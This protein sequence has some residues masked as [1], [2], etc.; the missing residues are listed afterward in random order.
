MDEALATVLGL[1]FTFFVFA[2]FAVVFIKLAKAKK[3]QERMEE[4]KRKKA[5]EEASSESAE[6]RRLRREAELKRKTAKKYESYGYDERSPF[7]DAAS[8]HALHEADAHEHGHTGEEEHYDEIVGS[9]GEVNDEGCAALSGVR[10]IANDIAYEIQ[11]KEAVD[12]DRIAQALVLGEIVNAP[13]FKSPHSR[14]K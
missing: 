7:G 1:A 5:A 6:E 13:R 2:V 11:T 12:Y 4:Y 8:K 3:T 14:K 9:L 10:F